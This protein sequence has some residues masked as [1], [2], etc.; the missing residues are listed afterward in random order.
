[1]AS[2]APLSARSS[3]GTSSVQAQSTVSSTLPTSLPSASRRTSTQM[4]P[5]PL[6][7]NNS[8][9]S[10]PRPTQ[11][12]MTDNAGVGLGPGPIRHPRPLTAAELHLELEKEQ[13]SI[14]NRLT[15]ELSAL[16]AQTASVASTT[17]STSESH[18]FSGN[19]PYLSTTGTSTTIIPTAARRHRSSSNLSTRSTRSIRD[20]LANA[21]ST[22]VSGVAA[23]RDQSVQASAR[24]S[25]ELS[26]PDVS[27][28]NSTSA[29]GFRATSGSMTSSPHMSQSGGGGYG[30]YS[31]SHRGSVS[32]NAN[33]PNLSN[34]GGAGGA[35]QPPLSYYSVPRSPSVVSSARL[36]EAA[37][38]RAELEAVKRENE[39]LKARVKELEKS[40]QKANAND[41][42]TAG[43]V[44][45]PPT[46]S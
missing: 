34:S 36:E 1:M 42:T 11:A 13:E 40:L 39:L 19:D 9:P 8:L 10:S 38:Q 23:P 35:E 32:S 44:L 27:R 12:T 20:T 4:L 28:Q 30:G 29:S 15:R 25:I 7:H 18:F 6:P 33:A 14:V 41:T 5:P 26:R 16:R 21:S 46:G 31:Y 22:S 45:S 24:P 37:L 17:S 43:S 3:L 2:D